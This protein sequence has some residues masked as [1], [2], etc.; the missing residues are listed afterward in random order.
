[1]YSKF[2][3]RIMDLSI[4][5]PLIA[6]TLPIFLSISFILFL[7]QKE[8][9]FFQRRPGLNG[10]LFTVFKFKT[11]KDSLEGNEVISEEKRITAPGKFLRKTNLDELPQLFNVLLGSMSLVGPRPF[12]TE[13]LALYSED[14]KKRHLVKPGITGWAQIN[15][16][17]NISWDKKL[18]FDLEYI[19]K[20][21]FGFDIKILI[22]TLLRI[23]TLSGFETGNF[24]P[25]KF[26]GVLENQPNK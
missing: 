7:T 8:V 21:N 15:G 2:L 20:S 13:Y 9:F 12:L 24:I 3:K 11:M 19:R 18:S 25:P 5:I 6:F 10:K 17:N 22:I 26:T 16:G 14:Q 23:L 1:M 4:S